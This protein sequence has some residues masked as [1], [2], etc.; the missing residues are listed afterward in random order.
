[1]APLLQCCSSSHFTKHYIKF[2]LQFVHMLH[3][4]YYTGSKTIALSE[5]ANLCRLVLSCWWYL[6]GK[7]LNKA[8]TEALL[9]PAASNLTLKPSDSCCFLKRMVE[10]LR[11]TQSDYCWN[12]FTWNYLCIW[13]MTSQKDS[14][15]NVWQEMET[16]L[17]TLLSVQLAGYC[18]ALSHT[19]PALYRN[20]I[21]YSLHKYHC[22]HTPSTSLHKY[23]GIP[24]Y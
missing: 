7:W 3:V 9:L 22:S 19:G 23:V 4:K 16:R 21:T 20:S 1:M 2:R 17:E 24:Q 18:T 15:V 14:E 12:V 8:R 5:M 11:P 13:I 6:S 10:M